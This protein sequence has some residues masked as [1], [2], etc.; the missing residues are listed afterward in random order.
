MTLRDD[1]ITDAQA[2]WFDTDGLAQTVSY[3]QPSRELGVA[4]VVQAIPAVISFGDNLG[5]T[6]RYLME[7]MVALIPAASVAQ[8][9]D[10]DLITLEGTVW[11]VRKVKLGDGLG[12]SWTLGCTRGARAVQRQAP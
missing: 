5:G 9:K 12:V 3:T 7:E 10:G 4:E 2:A 1:A 6:G 8:P 11:T